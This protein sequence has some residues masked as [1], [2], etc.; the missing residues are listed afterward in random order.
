MDVS[1]GRQAGAWLAT[2]WKVA[3]TAQEE[4]GRFT[5]RKA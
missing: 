5:L 2:K 4:S 3:D 1:D